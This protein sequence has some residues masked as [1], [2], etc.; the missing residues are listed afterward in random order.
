MRRRRIRD[1]NSW[2]RA[3]VPVA[4]DTPVSS[5]GFPLASVSLPLDLKRF[6]EKA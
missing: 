2:S 1:G 4:G 5:N 6:L 3:I